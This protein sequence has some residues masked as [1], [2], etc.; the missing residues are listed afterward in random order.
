MISREDALQLANQAGFSESEI[1]DEP[2]VDP[3]AESRFVIFAWLVAAHEREACAKV[4]DEAEFT[5][6]IASMK[7][8]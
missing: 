2:M 8:I 7:R 1:F 4:C 6:A 3:L 5:A